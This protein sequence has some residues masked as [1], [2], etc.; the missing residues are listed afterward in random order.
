[1]RDDADV[2]LAPAPVAPGAREVQASITRASA[3]H[4]AIFLM[5]ILETPSSCAAPP[6]RIVRRPSV[7]IPELTKILVVERAR[8]MAVGRRTRCADVVHAL[9]RRERR[10][11]LSRHATRRAAGEQHCDSCSRYPSKR[12]GHAN[13]PCER[14]QPLPQHAPMSAERKVCLT[15]GVHSGGRS[16]P[17]GGHRSPHRVLH[18][19]AA[20]SCSASM[21]ACMVRFRC[22]VALT[23]A[24]P[25]PG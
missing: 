25:S 16:P 6:L 12:I 2:A 11:R 20:T 23:V 19:A 8:A 18:H 10:S 21:T 22:V 9:V 24:R 3:A 13:T 17:G 5:C 15:Y 7:R 14:I 1:M 4:T